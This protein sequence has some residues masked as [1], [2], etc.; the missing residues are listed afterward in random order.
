MNCQWHY[1]RLIER[2]RTR[3]LSCYT[4]QHHVVPRCM[5]GTN[6]RS[7]IVA[8]T[9]EEHYVAHQLLAKL[10]PKHL[11]LLGAAMLLATGSG[12]R[13]QNKMYGWLKR[14]FGAAVSERMSGRPVPP[15]T[16][17]KLSVANKGKPLTAE[18][19]QK[20]SDAKQGKD[21]SP[22]V[23]ARRAK[24][25]AAYLPKP[26]KPRGPH[27]AE[28]VEKIRLALTGVKRGHLS[29]AH[30]ARLSVI[31]KGMPRSDQ[32]RANL[33][34]ALTGK[35]VPIEVRA[36]ISASLVTRM[37]AAREQDGLLAHV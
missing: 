8:L 11:G 37:N 28:T 6:A 21:A 1:D 35:S 34:A 16:K 19:R 10:Y 5:G 12:G 13:S 20:L 36:K 7:N 23:L 32:W 24:R 14:R 29:D 3:S 2:A 15:A 22:E 18:H 26:R 30:R 25:K 33:S 27:S 17:A 4:E 31:R 9:P